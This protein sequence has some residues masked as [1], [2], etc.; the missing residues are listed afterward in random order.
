[1]LLH[2]G[3]Y[4]CLLCGEILDIPLTA[5]PHVSIRAT[6]GEPN[7]RS[8]EF[9]GRVIHTCVIHFRPTQETREQAAELLAR[10]QEERARAVK[11]RQ[12]QAFLVVPRSKA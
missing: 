1:M 12:D 5:K 10:A 7:V 9:E 8:L 11:H 6:N 2:N 3:L 4:E